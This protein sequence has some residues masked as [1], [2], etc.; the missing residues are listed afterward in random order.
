MFPEKIPRL[1]HAGAIQ[2]SHPGV[3]T[4]NNPHSVGEGKDGEAICVASWLTGGWLTTI[5]PSSSTMPKTR[6]KSEPKKSVQDGNQTSN[7]SFEFPARWELKAQGNRLMGG[8]GGRGIGGKQAPAPP[9]AR[10]PIGWQRV[11]E[12]G[13]VAYISPSGTVLSSVEE[14]KTYLLT[15]GTCKCGLECPLVVHEVFCFDPRS[16]VTGRGQ[17]PWRAGQDMTKLCNHRRKVVAMAA[18][19]RSIQVSQVALP[20][21]RSGKGG[22]VECR[23][24]GG[25]S[26][27]GQDIKDHAPYSAGPCPSAPPSPVARNGNSSTPQVLICPPSNGSLSLSH[28]NSHQ[29][30]WSHGSPRKPASLDSAHSPHSCNGIIQRCPRPLNSQN[31]N[32]VLGPHHTLGSHLALGPT[33]S[34]WLGPP[35]PDPP[36]PPPSPPSPSCVSLGVGYGLGSPGSD[37]G[38]ATYPNGS[39]SSRPPLSPLPKHP[40]PGGE[41]T[42]HPSNSPNPNAAH[43]PQTHTAPNDQSSFRSPGALWPTALGAGGSGGNLGLTQLNQQHA[44]ATFPA[45]SLL[46]AAAKAQL[47]G[48]NHIQHQNQSNNT[49]AV[50]SLLQPR[51]C[52]APS[53]TQ[54]TPLGTAYCV[55]LQHKSPTMLSGLTEPRPP[56]LASHSSSSTSPPTNSDSSHPHLEKQR[57]HLSVTLPSS[58]SGSSHEQR[59]RPPSAQ[60]LSALLGMLSAQNVQATTLATLIPAPVPELNHAHFSPPDSPL[61]GVTETTETIPSGSAH[62]RCHAHTSTTPSA[63]SSSVP[64]DL[65][66]GIRGSGPDKAAIGAAHQNQTTNGFLRAMDPHSYSG[67]KPADGHSPGNP[68]PPPATPG[69]TPIQTAGDA[70]GPLQLAESFPFLSQDQ[71]LQLLSTAPGLPSLLTPPILSSLPIGVWVGGQQAQAPPSVLGTRGDLPVDFLGILNAPPST[72]ASPDPAPSTA[73]P[74]VPPPDKI[75]GTAPYVTPG[76]ASDPDPALGVE[77]CEKPGLQA[78]LLASVLLGQQATPI[79]PLPGLGPLGVELPQ[80]QQ[81]FLSGLE[82]GAV[83]KDSPLTGPG[84]LEA[85]QRW[86]LPTPP[87]DPP[88]PPKPPLQPHPQV[89]LPSLS[90]DSASALGCVS[91]L[92]DLSVTSPVQ[93][94]SSPPPPVMPPGV[95]GDLAAL[96]SIGGFHNLLGPGPLLPGLGVPLIPGLHPLTCLLNGVQLCVGEEKP[97]GTQ[98]VPSPAPQEDAAAN[99]L[100]RERVRGPA[101]GQKCT[102]RSAA[103]LDPYAS[104]MDTIYT[105]YLQASSSSALP[106]SYPLAPPLAPPP[107]TPPSLSPRRA[108]SLRNPEP[109]RLSIDAAQSPARGTPKPSEGQPSPPPLG[110]ALLEEA[111]TDC[112]SL[113]PYSNGLPSSGASGHQGACWPLP[114]GPRSPGVQHSWDPKPKGPPDLGGG[115]GVQVGGA[116]RGRKRRQV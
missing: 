95:L 37:P 110:R 43:R 107:V 72:V 66:N 86:L 90:L 97:T 63:V 20:G 25:L 61:I 57:A 98:E 80:Q 79:L 77:L 56:H 41:S 47:T 71:L 9:A 50:Y 111:K 55:T 85:L 65:S 81:Q 51:P 109:P 17:E 59:L 70:P 99:Q 3:P 112:A 78:L 62:R 108:C 19:C 94:K 89:P 10:V 7:R 27:K 1:S 5:T 82:G 21:R 64:Q 93:G 88:D 114:Q 105:S 91:E 40:L 101:G 13:A 102:G 33:A 75:I 48:Q 36:L 73:P 39:R 52:S 67:T 31:H 28:I 113:C 106:S 74:S 34:S 11:I 49:N 92:A 100:G 12:G 38:P 96:S 58:L 35:M 76:P 8:Q 69:A 18:L 6:K 32:L 87:P 26:L 30:H 46:S 54:N 83:E 24:P 84:L 45:S 60:P 115:A 29:S 14:V 16:E 4:S 23:D 104:F 68:P 15:D 116:R 103:V 53:P 44:T 42:L 2:Q 22:T